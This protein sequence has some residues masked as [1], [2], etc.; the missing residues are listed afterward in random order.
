M[1]VIVET[2]APRRQINMLR[3]ERRGRGDGVNRPVLTPHHPT[4][5]LS[6]YFRFALGTGKLLSITDHCMQLCSFLLC[7]FLLMTKI[8]H[9]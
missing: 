7:L 5:F 2:I 3:K 8:M 4:P 1:Y 9:R 6:R